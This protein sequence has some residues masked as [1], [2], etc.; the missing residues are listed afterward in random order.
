[1]ITWESFGLPN[2]SEDVQY[3]KQK[4]STDSQCKDM[5]TVIDYFDRTIT[6]LVSYCSGGYIASYMLTNNLITIEDK[7]CM[8]SSPIQVSSTT[9]KTVYETTF[10]PLLL[11]I[12]DD[13]LSTARLV[14]T[15]INKATTNNLKGIDY[16]LTKINHLPYNKDVFIHRYALLHAPWLKLCWKRIIKGLPVTTHILHGVDDD[17]VH[18]NNAVALSSLIVCSQ[19]NLY[20][21][22]GHF[23]VYTCVPLL[24]DIYQ[25]LTS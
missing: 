3:D 6:H 13:G 11:R 25:Y 20:Q 14:R 16:E 4:W 7:F 10:L 5:L 2:Y 8:I 17:I 1:V 22:H 12:A 9:D 24:N 19:L 23:A 18:S 15:I 21:N